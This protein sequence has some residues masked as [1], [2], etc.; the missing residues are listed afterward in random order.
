MNT[1]I[2]HVTLDSADERAGVFA[3][4][5][6]VTAVIAWRP[7]WWAGG[8]LAFWLPLTDPLVVVKWGGGPLA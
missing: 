7:W 2:L 6:R 5:D 3:S 1:T 8:G 4:G